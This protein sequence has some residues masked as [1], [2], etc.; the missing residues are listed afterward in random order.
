MVTVKVVWKNSGKP[1]KDQK[2]AL[3][4]D[5]FFSGGVTGGMWTDSNGEAHFDVKPNP[6]KVF[7]NGHTQYQG[8]LSGRL[9]VYI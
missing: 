5:T 4:I 8:H 3:A 2:V 1:A 7:V 6:G 9:V